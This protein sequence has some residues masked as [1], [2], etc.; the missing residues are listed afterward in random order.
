[1]P[2]IKWL[3]TWLWAAGTIFAAH[4]DPVW[5]LSAA[6]AKTS[7]TKVPALFAG[8]SDSQVQFQF[9]TAGA[10]R[11]KAIQGEL[12]DIVIVPTAAMNDL[13]TRQ[14]VVASSLQPLGTVRLGAAVA[15]GA[16]RLDLTDVTALK[17]ALIQA[18]SMGIADPSRGA[19]TGI[20]L[21]KLFANLGLA[22]EMK[23]KLKVYPEGQN[24][25]E[26]VAAREIEIAMGQLS[27]ATTVTGLEPLVPLPEAVQLKT[28]YVAAISQHAPHPLAARQLLDLLT[29]PQVQNLFRSNGFDVGT[30]P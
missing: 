6:A 8:I 24:A 28:V 3:V 26:A 10:M 7:V 12:F 9:G 20:Y 25:M 2:K 30:K 15:K 14:L 29:G 27:E 17:R 23:A 21:S 5:V 1:M 13:V 22:E 19:T 4:A 16:T 18:K 11:D